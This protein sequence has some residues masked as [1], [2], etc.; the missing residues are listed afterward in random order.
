MTELEAYRQEAE[1]LKNQIRVSPC[2]FAFIPLFERGHWN[3]RDRQEGGS[4]RNR[5]LG[6]DVIWAGLPRLM[7]RVIVYLW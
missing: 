6:W 2:F 7:S 1:T 4:R 5:S 3:L